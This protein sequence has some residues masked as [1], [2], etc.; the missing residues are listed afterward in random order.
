[1]GIGHYVICNS[2]SVHYG[3]SFL[4]I[5]AWLCFRTSQVSG[6]RYVNFVL[7]IYEKVESIRKNSWDL[8]DKFICKHVTNILVRLLF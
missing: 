3:V 7:V 2:Q 6:D 1:M 4:K 5:C 8:L